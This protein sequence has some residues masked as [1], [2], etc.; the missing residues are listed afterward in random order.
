M[1][2]GPFRGFLKPSCWG[3]THKFTY[4]GK[5]STNNWRVIDVL[6][7]LCEL[8]GKDKQKKV[9]LAKFEEHWIALR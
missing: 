1:H 3:Q 6:K 9:F 2:N 7:D 4:K 8:L 5:R